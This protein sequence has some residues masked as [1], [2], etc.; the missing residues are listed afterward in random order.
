M[1]HYQPW[2]PP[3]KPRKQCFLPLGAGV[4]VVGVIGS[5]L[6]LAALTAYAIVQAPQIRERFGGYFQ[7]TAAQEM[8]TIHQIGYTVEI[9]AV[10]L[11]G[12]LGILT[13]S[14]LIYGVLKSKRWFL[15]HWLVF[16]VFVVAAGLVATILILLLQTSLYKLYSLIPI[17]VIFTVIICWVK[18][19]QYFCEMEVQFIMHRPP[20][21]KVH[22][23]NRMHHGPG[24]MP[25][26]NIGGGWGG[27]YVSDWM[28]KKDDV[29]EFYPGDKLTRNMQD[30][31]YESPWREGHSTEKYFENTLYCESEDTDS[32]IVPTDRNE[33][34]YTTLPV[35]C[36]LHPHRPNNLQVRYGEDYFMEIPTNKGGRTNDRRRD[37]RD[38]RGG[39]GHGGQAGGQENYNVGQEDPTYFRDGKIPVETRASQESRTDSNLTNAEI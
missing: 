2:M 29:L 27:G 39:Q 31:M 30:R 15:L 9:I 37:D 7:Y 32:S 10:V 33:S 18:V 24:D 20:K 26:W 21:C 23:I 11:G 17:G 4:L 8:D 12:L 34:D 6:G 35:E 22:T 28:T 5:C 14:L 1:E 16:H 19:Y 13:N 38:V 25:P 3:G 36:K